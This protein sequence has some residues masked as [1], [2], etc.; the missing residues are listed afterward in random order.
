MY[1]GLITSVFVVGFSGI[2]AQT[3]LIRELLSIFEGN[4]FSLGIIFANWLFL[5]TIGI[6]F[7][8][9]KIADKK[10]KVF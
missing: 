10:E 3:V 4:E 9:K 5:E 8:S 2:I 6:A 7:I 1:S